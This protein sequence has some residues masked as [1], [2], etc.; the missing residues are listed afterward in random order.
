VPEF[1]L[2]TGRFPVTPVVSGRPVAFVN[3]P[4]AGVP[5][6]GFVNV[7][8]VKVLL[9]RVCVPVNV[10]TVLSIDMVPLE[11]IGPPVRPVPVLISVT[12][13]P[14]TIVPHPDI[15]YPSKFASEVL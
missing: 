13:E 9:V 3:T 5:K 10:T 15:V 14:A 4:D 6:A 7:G 2:P 1:R 8:L 12:A 11:V